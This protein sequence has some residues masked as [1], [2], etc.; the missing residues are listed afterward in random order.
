MT[1]F[2]ICKT[3]HFF[4]EPAG[5]C[6]SSSSA[7]VGTHGVSVIWP[8]WL[9]DVSLQSKFITITMIVTKLLHN[10]IIS[11]IGSVDSFLLILFPFFFFADTKDGIKHL[12]WFFSSKSLIQ[13]QFY[14]F[15][16]NMTA[17]FITDPMLLKLMEQ[18]HWLLHVRDFNVTLWYM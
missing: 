14:W 4:Q 13:S 8:W 11:D 2:T 18:V 10:S 6:F 17:L 16:S 5:Q 12:K 7:C 1:H 9:S 15:Q 3:W